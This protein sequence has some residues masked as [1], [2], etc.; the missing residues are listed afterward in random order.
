V[1]DIAEGSKLVDEEQFGPVMP[2]IK[3]TDARR[4]RAPRQ[5]LDLR[6]G[7]L[8]LGQGLRPR[9]DLATEM[10]SGSVWVNKHADIRPDLPFGGAKFSGVG[11]ELGE[12]GLKE[13]TPGPGAQHGAVGAALF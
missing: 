10:E 9:L 5:R 3:Y 13:F 11:S 4:R 8:D 12:E 7:R 1:R 2:V 6:P